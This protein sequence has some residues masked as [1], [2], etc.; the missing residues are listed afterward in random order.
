MIEVEMFDL[1]TP[2]IDQ[3]TASKGVAR[4]AFAASG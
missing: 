1:L 2:A 3:G 4:I